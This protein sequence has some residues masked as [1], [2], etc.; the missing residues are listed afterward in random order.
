[1]RI[2]TIQKEPFIDQLHRSCL[3]GLSLGSLDKNLE[4]MIEIVRDTLPKTAT[5]DRK[6]FDICARCI[7]EAQSKKE[8]EQVR[9]LYH[10]YFQNDDLCRRVVDFDAFVGK[11]RFLA[12]MAPSTV[13]SIFSGSQCLEGTLFEQREKDQLQ[14][15]LFGL[16]EKEGPSDRIGLS[17][18]T[19][20]KMAIIDLASD[21]GTKPSFKDFFLFM[22]AKNEAFAFYRLR[23]NHKDYGVERKEKALVKIEDQEN[24]HQL[25]ERLNGCMGQSDQP[26][27]LYS[28]EL[29]ELV[30]TQFAYR[31]EQRDYH[32][33]YPVI[34]DVIWGELESRFSLILETE[35]DQ[36]AIEGVL[37][38]V[39]LLAHL[40]LLKEGNRSLID[41]MV[42]SIFQYKQIQL[43]K[44]GNEEIFLMPLGRTV[45]EFS[46]SFKEAYA[47]ITMRV[48]ASESR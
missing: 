33:C 6:M 18:L 2:P 1:M 31:I 11:A 20:M 38:L 45:E 30:S 48:G 9:A 25:V 41:F 13:N 4:T 24:S 43:S 35:D 47:P 44:I 7:I 34:N 28:V 40:S 16:L 26:I 14:E 5:N 15:E 19:Y 36:E 3:E 22:A 10:L 27:K 12:C 23:R 29:G 42:L 21:L 39:W 8:V 17:C 32:V 37:E 46:A